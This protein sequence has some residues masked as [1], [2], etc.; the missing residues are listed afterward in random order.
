MCMS[1]LSI[2]Q[3]HSNPYILEI[4]RFEMISYHE[5]MKHEM[6]SVIKQLATDCIDYA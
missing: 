4:H 2:P 1:P 3:S 5:F 6:I